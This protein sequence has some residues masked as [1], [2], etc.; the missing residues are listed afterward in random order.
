M[1]EG[2]VLEQ[3]ETA[4]DIAPESDVPTAESDVPAADT[5]EPDVPAAPESQ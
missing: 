1:L 4:T 2:S 3:A 5:Q